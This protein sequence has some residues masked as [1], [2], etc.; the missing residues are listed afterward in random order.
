MADQNLISIGDDTVIGGTINHT[1]SFTFRAT[2]VGAGTMLAQII[3]LVEQA[4]GSKAPIQRLADRIAAVFVPVVMGIAALTFLVWL[5]LGSFNLALVNAVAVLIIACP[6]ALGLA[7]PTAIMVGTGRG[8]ERGILIR[9]GDILE[10]SRRV[11]A[12]VFDK[13]GTLTTGQVAVT[14]VAVASGFSEQQLLRYAAAA[15]AGS[16]HPIGKAIADYAAT[17]NITTGKFGDFTAQPG[18]GVAATVDGKRVLLGT[19]RLLEERGVDSGELRKLVDRLQ[20]EGKTT[21][22]AAVNGA[23]AGAIAVA[24]TV[25]ASAPAAVA[26]LHAMGLNVMMITGDHAAVANAIAAQL[27]IDQVLAE[28][29]P[30]DKA[31]RVK[32]LQQQGLVVAMVGDGINDAPALAQAD[33]GI[34]MGAGTDVAIESA[35]II[36]VGE[37]LGLAADAIRLS[38]ATLRVIKQN[39][40][41]AFI[42]NVIGIPVAAG[43]LYPAFG[44][45]LNPMIGAAAMAFSSVSVISN[46]LRLKRWK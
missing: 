17:R 15:E 5:V 39:L 45:L 1:G 40:F 19:Q 36:L 10:Q 29:L 34:A 27:G 37:N 6:C 22:L 43:V 20:Q 42:Y 7:P 18:F 28:V 4:Q 26:K 25:K 12:V 41:W 44:I 38:R 46:S 9:S 32:H 14:N 16:E 8:A 11:D 24:D 21:V 13:T 2:A 23:F 30:R 35:D 33:I 31:D 3:R